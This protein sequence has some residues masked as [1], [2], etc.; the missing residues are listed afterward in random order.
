M[1]SSYCK[2]EQS[3]FLAP[4]KTRSFDYSLHRI[5]HWV[6]GLKNAISFSDS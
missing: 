5:D 2:G 4:E 3:P 1:I 6:D